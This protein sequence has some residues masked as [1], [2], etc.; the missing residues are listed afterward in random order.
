MTRVETAC[1]PSEFVY[2]LLVLGCSPSELVYI[3]VYCFGF[4]KGKTQPIVFVVNLVC[5][6]AYLFVLDFS[7]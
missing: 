3:F 7:V 5:L 4:L 1:S 6:F 2:L